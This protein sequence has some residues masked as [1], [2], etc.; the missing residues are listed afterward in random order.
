[1]VTK[2]KLAFV[3]QFFYKINLFVYDNSDERS[4][5]VYFSLTL[6]YEAFKKWCDNFYLEIII[7]V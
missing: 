4:F 6:F 7:K 1:M 2:D 3:I 5:D